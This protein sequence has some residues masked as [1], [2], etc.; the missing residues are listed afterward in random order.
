MFAVGAL[1]DAFENFGH[2]IHADV[3]GDERIFQLVEQISVDFFAAGDG[4][5]QAIHQAGTR[6]LDA[7]LQAIEQVGFL[8]Y[9]AK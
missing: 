9:G 2:R 6:L 3:G 1:A 8:F 7:G 5:F 4:V